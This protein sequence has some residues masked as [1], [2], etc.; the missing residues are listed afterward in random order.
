MWAI[1]TGTCSVLKKKNQVKSPSIWYRTP[2]SVRILQLGRTG[3]RGVTLS[4]RLYD[5]YT[6]D[7][8]ALAIWNALDF[9]YKAEEVGTKKFLISKYFK[10]KFNGDMPILSQV[11]ELQVLVNQLKAEDVILPKLFQV[12]A[13]ISKLPSSWKSYRKKLLHDSKDYSLEE[14]QKHLRIEEESK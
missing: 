13:I 6:N 5:L 4:D 14:L 10:Y 7:K 3:N 2:N 11:H 9:K 1:P 12:R 8:S